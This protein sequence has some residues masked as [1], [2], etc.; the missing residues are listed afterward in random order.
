MAF[1]AA[2]LSTLVSLWQGKGVAEESGGLES[3]ELLPELHHLA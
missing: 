3:S 2:P 1:L